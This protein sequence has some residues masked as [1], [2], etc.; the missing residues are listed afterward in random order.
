MIQKFDEQALLY[1]Q[2]H[3]RSDVLT[4]V[5]QF[6]TLIGDAGAIWIGAGLILVANKATRNRAIVALGA[7]GVTAVAVNVV[8]KNIFTRPRPFMEMEGL[9]T[10]APELE[11]YSFPSGHASSSIAMATALTMLYGKKGAWS[12]IPAGI[13]AYSRSYLGVHYLTDIVVGGAF[14]AACA[15]AVV[16]LAK[17]KTN[18]LNK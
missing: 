10:L 11:S 14:G 7:L 17:K 6:F 5:M 2:D 1:I 8:L 9:I 15:W 12:F 4:E 18:L 16:K 13:I 3:L